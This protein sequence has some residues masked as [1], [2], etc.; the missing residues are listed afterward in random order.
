MAPAAVGA[1]PGVTTAGAGY[2]PPAP[3]AAAA[4]T[5]ARR[6]GGPQQPRRSFSQSIADYTYVGGDLRRIG[7]LA[8]S[9]VVLLVA[10][11]FFIR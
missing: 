4:A 7:L 3:R 11:S 1:V 8:G 6:P 10:L 2:A 5:V 9:L